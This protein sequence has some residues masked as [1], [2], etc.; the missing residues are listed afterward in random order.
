MHVRGGGDHEIESSAAWL[1]A[2]VDDGGRKPSPFAR[3]RRVDGKRVECGFDDAEPLR[4]AS[5]LVL[6][7][8]DEDAEVQLGKRGCADGAFEVARAFRP[9]P[10]RGITDCAHLTREDSRRFRREPRQIG[11]ESLRGRGLPDSL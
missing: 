6:R 2:A 9:D 8:R 10:D 7:V 1:P 3:D 11:V 5:S 4:P